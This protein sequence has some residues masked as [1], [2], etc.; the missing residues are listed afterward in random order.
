MAL[1]SQGRAEPIRLAFEQAGVEYSDS[2]LAP[3]NDEVRGHDM[4]MNLTKQ[5]YALVRSNEGASSA[6]IVRLIA[7][8]VTSRRRCC[9]WATRSS[10][11]RR[12]SFHFS[13]RAWA[14][15]PTTST[16][17]LACCRCVAAA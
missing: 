7:Q 6:S 10:R 12:R 14:S 9:A 8:T 4:R 1:K 3:E 16:A 2:A 15:R 13:A 17:V 5:M 11:R